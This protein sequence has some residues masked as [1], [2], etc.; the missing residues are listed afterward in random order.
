VKPKPKAKV[1]TP[2]RTAKK[3]VAAPAAS[4]HAFEDQ[5]RKRIFDIANREVG[6]EV[7]VD[8]AGNYSGRVRSYFMATDLFGKQGRLPSANWEWQGYFTTW[9]RQ[10]A[11]QPLGL[12]G[13]GGVYIDDVIKWAAGENQWKNASSGYRPKP[14][15]II[16][17]KTDST[18]PRMA[19]FT[20]VVMKVEGNVVKTVE[21]N[22]YFGS[23]GNK[24]GVGY[25]SHNIGDGNIAGYITAPAGK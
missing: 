8:S 18:L 9:V 4:K 5:I 16:A 20:G 2:P 3:Q 6:T 21:G 25:R 7:K 12:G 15:D 10:Q 23:G 1:V 14:G 13:G 11:G 17:F 22:I 19:N 24:L